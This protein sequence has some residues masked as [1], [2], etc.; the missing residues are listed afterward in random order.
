M[1]SINGRIN[2]MGTKVPGSKSSLEHAFPGANVPY[3]E[4]AMV[5]LG[6]NWPGS[7]KAVVQTRQRSPDAFH[8]LKYI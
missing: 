3:S 4:L 5:L 1:T 2:S 8:A 6:A 7:E